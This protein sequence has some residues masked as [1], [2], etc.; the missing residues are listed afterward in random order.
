MF[1]YQII[2]LFKIILKNLFKILLLSLLYNNLDLLLL[3]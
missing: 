2:K 1:I 3:L